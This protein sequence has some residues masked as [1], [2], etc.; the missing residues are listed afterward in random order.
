V[1]YNPASIQLTFTPVPEPG[2][3]LGLTVA[4]GLLLG[5][6]RRRLKGSVVLN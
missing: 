1:I 4:G 6:F 3:M 2:L 5:G